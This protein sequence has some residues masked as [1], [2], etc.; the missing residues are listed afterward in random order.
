MVRGQGWKR[1]MGVAYHI[2]CPSDC[3]RLCDS[4]APLPINLPI[5]V[6][7][8]TPFC[9]SRCATLFGEKSTTEAKTRCTLHYYNGQPSSCCNH[10][11]FC[12]HMVCIPLLHRCHVLCT[13]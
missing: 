10:M 11:T 4:C 6:V 3:Q 7:T 5:S 9:L 1:K 12:V 8:L 13:S 2:L